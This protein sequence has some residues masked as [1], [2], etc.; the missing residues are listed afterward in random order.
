MNIKVWHK[1]WYINVSIMCW[2]KESYHIPFR[3]MSD[4][5]NDLLDF[6]VH[7]KLLKKKKRIEKVY[8]N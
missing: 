6:Y 3:P 7:I 8:E 4:W 1:K 2:L 5:H